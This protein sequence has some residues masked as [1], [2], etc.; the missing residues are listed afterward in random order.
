MLV[1]TCAA[2]WLCIKEGHNLGRTRK[3]IL[4]S[5]ISFLLIFRANNGYKR[6]MK[7]RAACIRFFSTLREIICTYLVFLAGGVRNRRLRWRRVGPG[8]HPVTKEDVEMDTD[9]KIASEERMQAI[10]WC[11]VM[12]IA[13]QMHSRLLDQG[14]NKGGLT[15]ETKRRVDWD[16]YR[17]RGLLNESEFRSLEAVVRAVA[18]PN[19][20]DPLYPNLPEVQ[21]LFGEALQDSAEDVE[22]S[23]VPYVRLCTYLVYKLNEVGF[24]NMNDP[25]MQDKRWGMGERFV[26]LVT[27][28]TISLSYS[29]SEVNQIISTPLPFPYNHLCKLLLFLFF[30]S[31]PF[32]IEQ[33]LG[34]W[35][36][37][38]ENTLLAVALLG[39][40]FIATELENPFGED[41]NDLNM[42]DRIA[43]LE[44]EVMVFLKLCGDDACL[45]NFIWQDFPTEI[46]EGTPPV[47]KYLALRSQVESGGKEPDVVWGGACSRAH[48]YE[49]MRDLAEEDEEVDANFSDDS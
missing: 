40:D 18:A 31:F 2:Y 23:R 5:T 3:N 41:A 28:E 15:A 19:S 4:G 49:G 36:N 1:Y 37:I 25:R 9:D 7:G 34:L 27:A 32:F 30:L 22:I 11:L 39:M 16:R 20:W 42:Y 45:Q 24:R 47:L 17:I 48:I 43:T 35:V 33:E 6:Y 13:F 46:H 12:A 21:E 44:Q 29:Y 26:P 10:R 8:A 14:L 38:V